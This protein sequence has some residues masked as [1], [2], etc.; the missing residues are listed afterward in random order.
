MKKLLFL[1]FAIG[2]IGF[3]QVSFAAP[4]CS[5]QAQDFGLAN[6][7]NPRTRVH[8]KKQNRGSKGLRSLRS[9]SKKARHRR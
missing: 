7:T 6:N 2:L 4:I 8:Q 1:A 3:L 9:V 5:Q